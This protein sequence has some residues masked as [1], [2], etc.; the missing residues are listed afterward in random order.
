MH[1]HKALR[2]DTIFSPNSVGAAKLLDQLLWPLSIENR[3]TAVGNHLQ[4]YQSNTKETS[5]H[6]ADKA[7]SNDKYRYVNISDNL[8]FIHEVG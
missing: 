2:N 3:Q 4:M 8:L 6:K 1:E 7:V 5:E